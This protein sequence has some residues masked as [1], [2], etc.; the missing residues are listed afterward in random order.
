MV[1]ERV[2]IDFSVF[3]I[4]LDVLPIEMLN[5]ENVKGDAS[6]IAVAG[7]LRVLNR[8]AKAAA[9]DGGK[10]HLARP[11]VDL[12]IVMLIQ[13]FDSL[14]LQPMFRIREL[15]NRAIDVELSSP[16]VPPRERERCQRQGRK[17]A[18]SKV[19]SSWLGRLADVPGV[20]RPRSWS[21]DLNLSRA[22]SCG[23]VR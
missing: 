8:L 17:T 21:A 13:L 22:A 14:L 12:D 1:R 18:H 5:D 23:A 7:P 2:L 11:L 16:K 4:C 19:A 9:A 6:S 20:H 10:Y 3:L 15:A